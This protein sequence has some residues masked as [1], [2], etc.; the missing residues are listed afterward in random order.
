MAAD[1]GLRLA[2]LLG[3][4]NPLLVELFG[5][6]KIRGSS[7]GNLPQQ[8][9]LPLGQLPPSLP[10][11]EKNSSSRTFHAPRAYRVRNKSR[12]QLVSKG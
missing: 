10:C 2:S 6:L 5:P 8:H 3:L 4:G 1:S 7:L 9:P 12:K 11:Q